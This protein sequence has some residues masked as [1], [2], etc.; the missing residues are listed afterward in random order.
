M[1]V[2]L[3]KMDAASINA[4][5]LVTRLKNHKYI[6]QLFNHDP[7]C[8]TQLSQGVPTGT[9]GDINRAIFGGGGL[10]VDYI[11]KGTQTLLVPLLDRASTAYG[12]DISQDQTDND[13]VEWV[14]GGGLNFQNP[15]RFTLGTDTS[16]F[17]KL[18]MKIMDVSGTDDCAFGFR[19]I[20]ASQANIDDYDEMACV[21]VQLGN[22]YVETILNNAATVA[23]DSTVDW[24]DEATKTIEVQVIGRKP[25][26]YVDG[27]KLTGIPSYTFDSGE[28]VQPFL[29]FL[30]AT[31]TPGK[32][33]LQEFECGLL[34]DVNSSGLSQ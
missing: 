19:K 15:F 2:P 4:H 33:Y 34:A 18:K 27:V 6:Y 8:T 31:T 16:F 22:V 5:K 23:T 30:Q 14:F 20:E 26:Y 11:A 10:V 29:F 21:N 28:I 9:G 25:S 13:G 3:R 32:V 24:A 7:I 17:A 12:L 1:G